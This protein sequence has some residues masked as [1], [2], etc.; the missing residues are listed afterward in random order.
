MK[1]GGTDPCP[2]PPLNPPLVTD[3]S[4][5]HLQS[6]EGLYSYMKIF[7][8]L[9]T[10]NTHTCIVSIYHSKT[11]MKILLCVIYNNNRARYLLVI[12]VAPFVNNVNTGGTIAKIAL[13]YLVIYTLHNEW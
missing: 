12:C 6:C 8:Y 2:P 5:R 13:R 9:L 7:T 10:F 11:G 3:T 4:I 1:N